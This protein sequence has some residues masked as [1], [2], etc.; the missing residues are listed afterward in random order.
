MK[1]RGVRVPATWLALPLIVLALASSTLAADRGQIRLGDDYAQFFIGG[2]DWKPCEHECTTDTSCKAWTYITTTG[3]C[4]LKHSVPPATP[5]ACCVSGVKEA[6]NVATGDQGDCS[7]FTIDALNAND[8]NLSNRCGFT[9]PLWSSA[10]AT[11]YSRCLDG[12]PSRRSRDADERKQSLQ[13]CKQL[14]DRGGDLACDHYARL[15]VVESATNDANSCGFSGAAWSGSRDVHARW[16]RSAKR[17]AVNDQIASRERQ[18]LE[19]LGRGGGGDTDQAC[20]AYAATSVTQFAKSQQLRC[21]NGFDGPSWNSDQ[22]GHY[23]WCHGHS[24]ADR[25]AMTRSR[26]EA[27]GRCDDNRNHFRMIFKF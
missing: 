14:A 10:Y 26:D 3:Q 2:A 7:R 24:Q 1:Q 17:S 27:L 9:G 19:C 5:N 22:A 16:C 11:H 23:R 25:D 18:L 21:G 6:S 15:S 8:E 20:D 13:A 4:R 12:S